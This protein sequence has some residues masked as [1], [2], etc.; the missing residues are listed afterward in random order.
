[1]L[2]GLVEKYPS[3]R[4]MK[5]EEGTEGLGDP[6]ETEE[7]TVEPTATATTT[8]APAPG[9]EAGATTSAPSTAAPAA[10]GQPATSEG[11]AATNTSG[12]YAGVQKAL[13]GL[14]THLD[15]EIAKLRV[16]MKK[17][18]PAPAGSPENASAGTSASGEP[19]VPKHLLF[20]ENYNDSRYREEIEK[21]GLS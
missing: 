16:E 14:Q 17:G 19:S 5:D 20:P 10:A 18:V 8:T 4:A 7:V 21:L 15:S 3:V 11:A 2:R 6:V 13:E 12:A 1:M 9:A